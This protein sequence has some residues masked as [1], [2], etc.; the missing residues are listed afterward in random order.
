MRRRHA[1]KNIVIA[2]S[3]FIAALSAWRFFERSPLTLD[4]D[5]TDGSKHFAGS[6]LD[7]ARVTVWSDPESMG[8]VLNTEEHETHPAVT[9]DGSML[10][11]Q[12][13]TRGHGADL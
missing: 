6:R 1:S 12:V 4:G 10:F 3:L 13:G 11:F 7:G 2:V 8:A 9:P 5:F